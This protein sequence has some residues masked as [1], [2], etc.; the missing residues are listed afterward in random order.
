MSV[1]VAASDAVALVPHGVPALRM[2]AFGRVDE[3]AAHV[4][5]SACLALETIRSYS[6]HV[7]AERRTPVRDLLVELVADLHHLCDQSGWSFE[8]VLGE[9]ALLH[10][11]EAADPTQG[12]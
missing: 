10:A 1:S 7:G 4:V 6:A 9:A 5:E 12:T 2:D 11:P 3:S 8:A